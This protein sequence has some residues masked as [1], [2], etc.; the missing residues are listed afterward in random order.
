MTCSLGEL[1]FTL[2]QHAQATR[3][4]APAVPRSRTEK[5]CPPVRAHRSAISGPLRASSGTALRELARY[6]L[7]PDMRAVRSIAI[8]TAQ[9]TSN[10]NET[11]KE[12]LTNDAPSTN[13]NEEPPPL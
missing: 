11:Y 6:N 9:R 8:I 10:T 1:D 4:L 3:T 7:V 13:R 5:F 12:M 2:V